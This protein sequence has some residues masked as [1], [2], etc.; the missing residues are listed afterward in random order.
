MTWRERDHPRDDDGQFTEAGGWIARAA[1]R[2][3]PG[4]ATPGRSTPRRFVEGEFRRDESGRVSI[5][6]PQQAAQRRRQEITELSRQMAVGDPKTDRRLRWGYEGTEGWWY[7]PDGPTHWVRREGPPRMIGSWWYDPRH[8]TP[9]VPPREHWA[10]R[11]FYGIP[12]QTPTAGPIPDDVYQA[13]NWSPETE[14]DFDE[15][16]PRERE[17]RHRRTR[18]G[19][20]PFMDGDRIEMLP[21]RRIA[22][23]R[24]RKK[25]RR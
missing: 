13:A 8:W 16:S 9:V 2:L 3:Q 14:V 4:R 1:A 17:F 6:V 18:L 15:S 19:V 23:V 12:R 22:Q 25:R 11:E 20:E 10:G 7:T 21:G 5:E 24:G